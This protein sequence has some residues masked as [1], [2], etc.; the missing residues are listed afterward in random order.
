[1]L[2]V[3]LPFILGVLFSDLWGVSL[4][5]P[6]I[7]LLIIFAA[8]LYTTQRA[9]LLYPILFCTGIIISQIA[10][11]ATP[12]EF[13]DD[14]TVALHVSEEGFG[15]I[16]SICDSEGEWQQ[17]HH[18]VRVSSRE[19]LINKSLICNVDIS[20]LIT[21]TN[22]YMRNLAHMGYEGNAEI[23]RVIS[24][25]NLDSEPQ[26]SKLNTWATTRLKTLRL[27]D[28]A[29]ATAASMTLA[30]KE[31]M[32]KELREKYNVSGAAHMLSLSGLH[33][34]IVV[35]LI[36]TFTYLLPLSRKGHITANIV[37]ILFIWLFAYMVGLGES[38]QRAA[39]MLSAIEVASVVS[40]QYS[41]LNALLASAILIVIIDPHSIYDIG[42]LLAFVAVLSI[43]LVAAPLCMLLTTRN[44][45]IDFVMNSL[46]VGV[47]AT[48]TTAP[49][50][51]HFFGYFSILGPF[52]TMP[53]VLTLTVIIIATL[54]WIIIPLSAVAPLFW[55]TIE[56]STTIQNYLVHIFAQHKWG[57]IFFRVSPEGLAISYIVLLA[58]L[59]LGSYLINR[60]HSLRYN[61]RA[62]LKDF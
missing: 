21:S 53:L 15:E 42:F 26:S 16:L 40:K 43:I 14:V 47:I 56:V 44:I 41:G 46:I 49:L 58:M 22:S 10:N 11:P 30:H 52:T 17:T 54:L 24:H 34:S 48:V 59:V 7:I 28:E 9:I 61:L 51:S 8:V 35:I 33:L 31:F 36:S 19:K 37:T 18:L 57:Y 6:T 29:F 60:K 32:S 2:G 55:W 62:R 23:T 27:N 13:Q 50:I 4:L 38:V 5:F 45:I 1:M 20:P 3:L 12:L 25:T 39:I